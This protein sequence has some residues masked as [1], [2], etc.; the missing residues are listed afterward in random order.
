MANVVSGSRVRFHYVPSG[1]TL[2]DPV[3]D[4][5]VYFLEDDQE[6]YV[7]DTLFMKYNDLSVEV[8]GEGTDIIDV[9]Y[10][11]SSNTLTIVRG[12]LGVT[13]ATKSNV[14]NAVA[15][16]NA[17]T[18]DAIASIQHPEYTVVEVATMGNYH[19]AYRLVK[20][21]EYVGSV[22]N[23]P[24]YQVIQS[25]SVEVAVADGSPY[26][27]AVVGDKYIDLVTGYDTAD[28]DNHIYI[29]VNDL[30]DVYTAGTG[31]SIS[32]TNVVSHNIINDSAP[33]SLFDM[34]VS[35]PYTILLK[36]KSLTRDVMGHL[37]GSTT[38]TQAILSKTGVQNLI[39]NNKL[40]W[41]IIP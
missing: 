20:D 21:G 9:L 18:D 12:D 1:S 22:I 3:D 38:S 25:S 24:E 27:E 30:V 28:P 33:I 16:A 40:T 39:T 8:E 17:Y 34:D 10:T 6:I 29:P 36:V 26:P 31:L 4:N 37:T 13:Y 15:N 11:A 5:T 35:D 14:S 32:N 41:E 7:G 19:T 2:P 23:I